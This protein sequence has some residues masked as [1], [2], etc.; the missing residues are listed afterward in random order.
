MKGRDG[1]VKNLKGTKGIKKGRKRY[2]KGGKKVKKE[3]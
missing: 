2:L 3:K 1:E